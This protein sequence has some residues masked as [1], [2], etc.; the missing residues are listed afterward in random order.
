MPARSR[1][2]ISGRSARAGV[3]QS[4]PGG[5]ALPTMPGKHTSITSLVRLPRSG[6]VFGFGDLFW[7]ATL[8]RTDG[9]ILKHAP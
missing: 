9:L 8:T 3:G 1:A 2:T 7:G 4:W 5:I 6:T